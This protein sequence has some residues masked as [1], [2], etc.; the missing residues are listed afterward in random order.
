M[1]AEQHPVIFFDGVCNLC[2]GFVQFIIRRDPKAR[3]RFAAL[4]SSAAR[5]VLP[6]KFFGDQKLSSVILME[7]G[8]CY[9]HSAAALRIVRSLS[10]AWPLLYVFIGVPKFLRDMI[11]NVIAVNRY[12]W[13]GKKEK[14]MIPEPAIMDRFIQS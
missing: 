4:Q 12:R 11:Y 7:N 6:E 5:Q 13:F 8:K 1:P 2:N 14:C 9:T 10:G 3:F